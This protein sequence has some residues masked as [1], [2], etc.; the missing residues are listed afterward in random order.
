MDR[1]PV[2]AGKFY[3]A[4][5]SK[6]EKYIS[7]F[8]SGIQCEKNENIRAIISPHAGYVFSGQVAASVFAL[9]NTNN[10]ENVFVIASSHCMRFKGASIYNAGN[11]E[12]PLGTVEINTEICNKLISEN[13]IFSFSYD[14]HAQEHSVEVQLPFLQHIF[15]NNFRLIPVVIG[16]GSEKECRQIADALK[17][18]FNNKN[19]FVI[20]TDFSH[21]PDYKNA[22]KTDNIT[23]E[24]IICNNSGKFIKT[25]HE[26]KKTNTKN[27]ST[28]L[29]G[30]TS[31]LSLLYITEQNKNIEYK[32]ILYKN[33]GD[34]IYGDYDSVVGYYG[35]AVVD[36]TCCEKPF[37]LS[38]KE[39]QYLLKLARNTLSEYIIKNK[40]YKVSDTGFSENIN[41]HC[42]VFVSLYKS[43][44]L[45][46]CIGSFEPGIPLWQLVQEM[47][48]SAATKDSRFD[49]VKEKEL[50][51][52]KIEISVLTPLK[53]IHSLEDLQLGKHGIYIK[54]GFMSGT[55]LPQ[56]ATEQNW[57][58]EEFAGYCSKNKAGIGYY[59]WKNAELY[60][61][62][63]I[64]FKEKNFV[65]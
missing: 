33:S 35:I 57:T 63:T 52:I 37:S 50:K 27:L 25:L 30:W 3:S 19:L 26:I 6:L 22:V 18:Y 58:K 8:F 14:A 48:I 15:K 23:A 47:T 9:I 31:V 46:G 7:E 2:V 53:R 40:F 1:K 42:G 54:S 60:I 49:V 12:T 65:V 51:D 45:R 55:F 61:Y 21:Y 32:K 41:K 43:G 62:E 64:T 36:Y 38:E 59:G 10:Y 24:A 34:S 28:A 39:K 16:T 4:S 5:K 17:P 11:Y 44:R 56:V 29:C 13:N 20:S